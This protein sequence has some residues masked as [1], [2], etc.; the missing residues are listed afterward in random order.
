MDTMLLVY[1]NNSLMFGTEMNT[2]TS[3]LG[4]IIERVSREINRA[5]LHVADYPVGLL[6]QVL[7]VKELLDVGS[8]DVVHMIGIHGMGGLGKTTLSLAVYNLIADDFDSSC[9]L[10]DVREKSNK[11]GLK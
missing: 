3:L 4:G 11:H 7:E 8:D 2:S 1:L 6:P 10:Q 9:F 5:S